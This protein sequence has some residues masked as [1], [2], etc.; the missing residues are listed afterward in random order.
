[1]KILRRSADYI[2]TSF[3]YVHPVFEVS[4][5]IQ[6]LSV[7]QSLLTYHNVIFSPFQGIV[8]HF[9]PAL[10]PHNMVRPAVELLVLDYCL[11]LLHPI[12]TPTSVVHFQDGFG[13]FWRHDMV[14]APC[15]QQQWRAISFVPVHSAVSLTA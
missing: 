14:L 9:F 10:L 13:Y 11:S 12:P 5:M 6:V 8:G 1:M 15:N 7:R 3:S 2:T 4:N